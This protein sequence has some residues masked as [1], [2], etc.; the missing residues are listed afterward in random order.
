[1]NREFYDPSKPV[2]DNQD[3]F[4]QA[5]RQGIVF[6]QQQ[7]LKKMQPYMWVYLIV[8]LVFFVWAL[9]LAMKVPPGQGKVLHILFALLFSPLY[10]IS[11]YLGH[12]K[13]NSPSSL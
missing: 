10:V 1:M 13:S 7:N 6:N 9:M 4:N 3:D 12:M 11:H 5:L 8:F 2:C